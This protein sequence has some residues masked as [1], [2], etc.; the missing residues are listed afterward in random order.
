MDRELGPE[1]ERQWQRGGR[2]G[3]RRDPALSVAPEHIGFSVS[4]RWPV[5]VL[6]M[7]PSIGL[8]FAPDDK[9]L[10]VVVPTLVG[11]VLRL[12]ASSAVT[13]FGGR[14]W[15][16]FASLA[17]LVPTGLTRWAHGRSRARPGPD[18]VLRVG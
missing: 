2:C 14:D 5:L 12:P 18:E 10:L 16:V 7:S 6:F 11:A 1:D 15:T 9:F 3:A 4:S 8:D 13:R 17:L